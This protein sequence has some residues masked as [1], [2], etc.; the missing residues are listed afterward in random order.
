[1]INRN[2]SP[3]A[4]GWDFQINAG[5]V[6]MLD[7]ILDAKRIRMEGATED[8]EIYFADGTC[9]Y[10][11]AKST[12]SPWDNANAGGVLTKALE[13]LG[14]ACSSGNA[15]ELVYVTNRA[16]PFGDSSTMKAFSDAYAKVP[17][18]TLPPVCQQRVHEIC[19]RKGFKLESDRFSVLSLKFPEDENT[20]YQTIKEH[21]ADFLVNI[22]PDFQGYSA[23]M[24]EKWQLKFGRN[25]TQKNPKITI[26]KKDV[27]WPLI[28]FFCERI[29]NEWLDDYD[30]GDS[31]E[32]E[33]VYAKVIAD[34]SE[35]F[36]FV[37]KVLS[38]YDKFKKAHWNQP[39][40]EV[41]QAF[42]SEKASL[43]ADE[44]D[45]TG[46]HEEIAAAVQKLTIRKIL[47]EKHR[48]Q[49]VKEAVNL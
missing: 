11:Q 12:Q 16:D 30:E 34:Q 47:V 10:A 32:I 29:N 21:I 2:A 5:I 22:N 31:R 42:I 45:L 33:A 48:I 40:R 44:F 43:F 28:V 7:N 6:L 14:D 15:R 8:I 4:F 23:P 26:G 49:E 38:E 3:A 17:F 46:V 18:E 19:A 41:Q 39:G 24:M 20:R 35:R 13:T 25:A 27:I 9:L 36:T 37:A 1:M